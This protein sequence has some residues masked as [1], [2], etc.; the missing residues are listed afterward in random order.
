MNKIL[1][2]PHVVVH[3]SVCVVTLALGLQGCGQRGKPENHISCSHECEGM[4]THTPKWVP[5]LGV[6][7]P[8]DFQNFKEQL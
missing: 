6:G 5:I 2:K 1:K 8:M 7:V 3:L 4:N